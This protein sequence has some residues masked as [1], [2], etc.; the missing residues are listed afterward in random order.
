MPHSLVNNT[1]NG[2]LQFSCP[3]RVCR[4]MPKQ[5][6]AASYCPSLV[7]LTIP[8]SPNPIS[9]AEVLELSRNATWK[10]LICFPC[11]RWLG[12]TTSCGNY[13]H[14][15]LLL[16]PFPCLIMVSSFQVWY[17]YPGPEGWWR[18][19]VRALWERSGCL[20]GFLNHKDFMIAPLFLRR[21]RDPLFQD[22]PARGRD[23]CDD[24]Q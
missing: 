8:G 22:R 1:N 17:R 9:I 11:F 6:W 12:A 18:F 5:A 15:F 16:L 14:L 13:F 4:W 10:V 20:S 3:I 21:K 2:S 24:A 19:D 23:Y 7:R